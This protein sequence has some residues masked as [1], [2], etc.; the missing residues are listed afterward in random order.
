ME[1]SATPKSEINILIVDDDPTCTT[2]L[3]RLLSADGYKTIIAE[4][5][6]G[7]I[8][9]AMQ[10]LPDLILLDIMMPG[11]DG[12]ETCQR[13]KANKE[14][15]HIPVIFV[16]TCTDEYSIKKGFE[17]G[18]EDYIRKPILLTEVL[19]RVAHQLQ[20]LE[21]IKLNNLIRLKTKKITNLGNMVTTIAHE[22]SSPFS[23]L[24]LALN[25]LH[26]SI[27]NVRQALEDNILKSAQLETFLDNAFEVV[28]I[29]QLNIIQ[30]NE[31]LKS[32]KLI[33][34]DQ[35]SNAHSKI[36]LKE[37]VDSILLSIKPKL[38]QKKHKVKVNIPAG[39]MVTTKPGAL[40][41]VII[42]LISNS[43]LHAFENIESGEINI[44]YDKTAKEHVLTYEDNGCGIAEDNMKKLF[45]KFYTTK[46]RTGG[47]GLGMSIIKQLVQEELN[48]D[49]CVV[50]EINQG[51][52]TRIILPLEFKTHAPLPLSA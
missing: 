48:G 3:D 51:M 11:I 47:S 45:D 19:V 26:G 46:K 40:S 41:Q 50:S 44:S 1:I 30:A 9:A 28:D 23:T 43:Y 32:F 33:A 6:Q 36:D 39:C 4:D 20:Y 10:F 15:C 24:Q 12:F 7:A 18:A 29:S 37:Y 25:H 16:T 35:C 49:I 2:I 17:V 31:V 42:N 27:S 8:N 14:T 22:V 13:I 21:R 34:V 38:R 5:G 52:S